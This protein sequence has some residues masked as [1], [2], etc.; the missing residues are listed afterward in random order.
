MSRPVEPFL[1]GAYVCKT[2]GFLLDVIEIKCLKAGVLI[3][4]LCIWSNLEKQL[5]KV[6]AK[7]E[8]IV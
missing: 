1:L 6:E 4:L 2:E 7:C 5:D 3:P 8:N